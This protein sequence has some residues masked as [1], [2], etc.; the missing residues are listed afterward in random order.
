MQG[1]DVSGPAGIAYNMPT[2][3]WQTLG[4]SR[5]DAPLVSVGGPAV[6]SSWKLTI[7]DSFGRGIFLPSA[8]H[9]SVLSG[10]PVSLQRMAALS[11]RR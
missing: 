5:V 3:I 1:D 7:C 2:C 9:G 10:P 4:P 6:L 11:T 8:R